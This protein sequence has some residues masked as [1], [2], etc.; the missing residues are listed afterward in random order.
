MGCCP[1]FSAHAERKRKRGPDSSASVRAVQ[2]LEE[3]QL[4]FVNDDGAGKD[5][6]PLLALPASRPV[7]IS[8]SSS[9]SEVEYAMRSAPPRADRIASGFFR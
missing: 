6:A 1:S 8:A 7:H 9:S 2:A 5:G 3:S 4:A